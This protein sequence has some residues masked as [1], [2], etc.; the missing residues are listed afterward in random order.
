M[1]AG[2]TCIAPDYMLVQAGQQ[3]KFAAALEAVVRSGYADGQ[4]VLDKRKF[5]QIVNKRNFDRIKSLYDDAV[6]KG[7][8][9]RRY[10][11]ANSTRMTALFIRR[12]SET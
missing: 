4:G 3:D 12:F 2:Q 6:S 10:W 5:A 7:A 11:A 9:R 8:E 1:N